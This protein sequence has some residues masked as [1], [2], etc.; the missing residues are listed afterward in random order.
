MWLCQ[1]IT[2]AEMVEYYDVSGCYILRPWSF[3]IWE[4][5]Q[6]LIS[7]SILHISHLLHTHVVDKI[8]STN[9]LDNGPKIGECKRFAV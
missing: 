4:K 9:F 7:S 3:A 1:V 8:L 5:I 6:G 2:K